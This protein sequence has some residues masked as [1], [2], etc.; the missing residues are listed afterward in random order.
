VRRRRRR[1]LVMFLGRL[2]GEDED[3]DE[4]VYAG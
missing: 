1:F 2:W 4:G 3:E